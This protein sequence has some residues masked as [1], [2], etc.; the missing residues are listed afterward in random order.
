MDSYTKHEAMDRAF[1]A[2]D[3]VENTLVHHEYYTSGENEEF[4][5]LVDE[6][7]KCLSEAYQ[8]IN[9]TDMEAMKKSFLDCMSELAG[10]LPKVEVEVEDEDEDVMDK[11]G[12]CGS[13]ITLLDKAVSRGRGIGLCSPCLHQD[14]LRREKDEDAQMIKPKYPSSIRNKGLEVNEA[15]EMVIKADR[16]EID[17]VD[18]SKTW[19]DARV[20]GMAGAELHQENVSKPDMVNKPPHYKDASG[21]E[22]KEI[23][24]HRKMPFSLGN[25]IKYLYRAGSK[26]DL[27]EDLKK[28]EWYLRV[29]YLNDEKV[30]KAVEVRLLEVAAHRKTET[31]GALNLIG[32]HE[33]EAA[34]RVVK[35]EIEKM[36][37]GNE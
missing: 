17:G 27:L 11:C 15:K 8:V 32:L 7:V 37:S 25:A 5:K 10:M 28:A 14:N 3:Y 31:G 19:V 21:I 30:P 35:S 23:T 29:A 26:G 34:Y 6:A 18:M 12:K 20:K 4:N 9:R 13:G 2:V 36:E 22:C 24:C 1:L 33:T 16:L